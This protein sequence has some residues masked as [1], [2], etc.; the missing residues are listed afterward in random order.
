MTRM[1]AQ[2]FIR[3]EVGQLI[4]TKILPTARA[5]GGF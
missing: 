1:R 5:F 2:T 4:E 3:L